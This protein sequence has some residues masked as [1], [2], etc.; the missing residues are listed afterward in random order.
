[1]NGHR[2]FVGG[3]VFFGASLLW[4]AGFLT[5]LLWSDAIDIR[6]LSPALP[7]AVLGA[8]CCAVGFIRWN[9]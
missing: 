1:M 2:W 9:P 7:L 5:A 3:F 6:W 4:F 8:A